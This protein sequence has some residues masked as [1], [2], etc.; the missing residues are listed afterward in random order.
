MRTI[1]LAL[2]IF[3][4]L[5]LVTTYQAIAQKQQLS[6][7]AVISLIT[8]DPG[9]E[10][11]SL[12]G[13][14]AIRVK[15]TVNNQDLVFNYGTFNFNTPNFYMKFTRGKLL[16]MLSIQQFDRFKRSY[17][18]EKRDLKEQILN[19]TQDQKQAIFQFL[20]WNYQPENRYYKYDFFFD[21]C[22]TRIRDVFIDEL[23]G[24]NF[25]FEYVKEGLVSGTLLMN[26]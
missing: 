19:L 16:Y 7:Q 4:I 13:H 21:N 20:L 25:Q 22:A 3:S 12:F 24:L 15:D 17:E 23:P 2:T 9:E 1:N 6:D 8:A 11:Y 26:T 14:S 10:L 5:F 18:Y